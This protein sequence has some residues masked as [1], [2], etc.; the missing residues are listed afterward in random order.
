MVVSDDR[1]HGHGQAHGHVCISEGL[2]RPSVISACK[3]T[4]AVLLSVL[5]TGDRMGAQC[6]AAPWAPG[7][8]T[9]AVG[10]ITLFSFTSRPIFS[11]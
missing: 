1:E 8:L 5:G 4:I 3:F 11:I 10:A 6:P 7:R 2:W 9:F